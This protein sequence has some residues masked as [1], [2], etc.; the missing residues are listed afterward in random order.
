[1]AL[2]LWERMTD[3]GA[4]SSHVGDAEITSRQQR[5]V[6]SLESISRKKLRR[7]QVT[8]VQ[9]CVPVRAH[10]IGFLHIGMWPP[11]RS[12]ARS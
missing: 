11:P 4:S 7:L 8:A 12:C 2:C 6:Q 3:F 10:P 9:F 5:V 1:M